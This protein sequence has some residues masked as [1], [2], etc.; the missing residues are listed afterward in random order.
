MKNKNQKLWAINLDT[1]KKHVLLIDIETI[2][3]ITKG[4]K[5][6]PFDISYMVYDNINDKVIENKSLII[7]DIYNNKFL[8][9]MCYYK[10]NIPFYN[11]KLEQD[12]NYVLTSG[13]NAINELKK[14]IKRYNISLMVAYNG[15]FDYQGINNLCELLEVKSP[16]KKLNVLCL[17]YYTFNLVKNSKIYV[18][19]CEKHNL[20]SASGKN[21]STS[22]ETIYKFITNNLHFEERHTGLEDLKIE[23]DI[24]KAFK[25][26][27][28]RVNL[29]HK[30]KVK[31]YYN[32]KLNIKDS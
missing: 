26:I 15:D 31:D 10:H 16:I 4:D 3:D 2:G 23:L 20:K 8:M 30:I 11:D 28:A 18:A 22:A 1:Y 14:V 13:I 25:G 29:N 6:F 24:F 21:Y 32:I 17:W 5:A 27:N 19:F 9:E 7:S 12:S